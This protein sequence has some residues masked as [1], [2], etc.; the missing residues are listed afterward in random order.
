MRDYTRVMK[1]GVNVRLGYE[2][3]VLQIVDD[4]LHVS[5][6]GGTRLY[7]SSSVE[8]DGRIHDRIVDSEI[9]VRPS[10]NRR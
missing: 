3:V 6:W 5:N 4:E 7:A 10:E 1:E 9:V 2:T 8:W